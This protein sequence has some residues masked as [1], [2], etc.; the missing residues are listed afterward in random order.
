MPKY[1]LSAAFAAISKNASLR[2]SPSGERSMAAT[3]SLFNTLTSSFRNEPLTEA[4]GWRFMICL[5][6]ARSVQGNF[7]SD[8]YVD[9]AGY[10]ALLAS[11]LSQL[12]SN[13]SSAE[14]GLLGRPLNENLLDKE[15]QRETYE[16]FKHLSGKITQEEKERER[17]CHHAASE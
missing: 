17:R 11:H 16:R 12:S 1:I 15:Q 5:K 13:E 8:D 10:S 4:D 2:D 6:L 9:I 14:E 3:V 7:N